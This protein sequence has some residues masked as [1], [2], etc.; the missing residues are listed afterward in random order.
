MGNEVG[1]SYPWNL[2]YLFFQ[3]EM[4]LEK[5]V[6][7]STF[8]RY[9]QGKEMWGSLHWYGLSGTKPLPAYI[10]DSQC[11]FSNDGGGTGSPPYM[12]PGDMGR[13]VWRRIWKLNFGQDKP[14]R[15]DPRIWGDMGREG[16]QN[17]S[18]CNTRFLIW[19]D[20]TMIDTSIFR[21]SRH[22][23]FYNESVY[24]FLWE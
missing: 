8:S 9:W 11:D 22:C 24:T 6:K 23:N 7:T 13:D 15:F 10:L 2:G 21:N 1:N 5:L 20:T 18:K 17:H 14:T 3:F 16:R 12:S 19:E 4:R